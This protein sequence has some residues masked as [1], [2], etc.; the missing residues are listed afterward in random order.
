MTTLG[1][2][3]E[4]AGGL[5]ATHEL[6]SRGWTKR[7][8]AIAVAAGAIIRVRQGWYV[9][10]STPELQRE[11]V[12]VGGRLGCVSGARLLGLSVRTSGHVH[13]SV[14]PHTAR[15]RSSTDQRVRLASLKLS[16]VIVHWNDAD[17]DGTRFVLGVRECLRQMSLCQSPEW[18]VA[19]AD[20]AV[21]ARLLTTSDWFDDIRVLPRR[22]RRLLS[23]VDPRAE[24]ITESV[25]RFR[26]EQLGFEPRLQ[27]SIRGVGRV[28]MVIGERLV[29]EVD[30]YA[31]HSDPE[32]F[33]ADRRRDARLSARGY[34]V[35]RFSY[36][37][38]MQ[39][40]SEVR[41]AITAAVARG[42]HL[43]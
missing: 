34:R 32:A 11:G 37:Q 43:A 13:V 1:Q 29:I 3:I 9:L 33:E 14:S 24:S 40:W 7:S 8:L 17:A 42:D 18:V 21:R 12:R 38:I 41:A 2:D 10:P 19:A 35:L 4:R 26:L 36:R 27:V 6:Y 25:T 20:S 39:R 30:G 15:L 28:D 5:A 22:L 16:G 31:Y 23:R